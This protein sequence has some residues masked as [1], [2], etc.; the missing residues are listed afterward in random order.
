MERARERSRAFFCLSYGAPGME[1]RETVDFGIMAT[2]PITL[3]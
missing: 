3:R 1:K 2:Y